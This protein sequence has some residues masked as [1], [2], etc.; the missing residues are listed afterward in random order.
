[1]ADAY[2][3]LTLVIDTNNQGIMGKYGAGAADRYFWPKA[4][5]Q[6]NGENRVLC[7][8]LKPDPANPGAYE[9]DKTSWRC[10]VVDDLD[11]N[12]G[13]EFVVVAADRPAKWRVK[14]L[15]RQNC[16]DDVEFFR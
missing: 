1:M 3:V 6:T 9:H 15:R 4:L 8:E 14:N 10:F 2:A 11:V 12:A 7:V 13:D 5:G 16:V